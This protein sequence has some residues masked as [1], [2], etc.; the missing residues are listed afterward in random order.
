LLNTFIRLE[1]KSKV[2]KFV[3]IALSCVIWPSTVMGGPCGEFSWDVSP[4]M[5]VPEILRHGQDAIQAGQ[6][7]EA[8]DMFATYL[9]EQEEGKFAE[10]SRWVMAS[11]P[12]PSDVSGREIFQRITR[13]QAMKTSDPDSVYAPWALCATGNIY[14]E[15]GWFSEASGIFEEFLRS[16]PEHPLAGG[17]MV[18][19]GL[20]YMSNRQYLE[21]ALVLRRVVEEPKWSAHRLKGALGLADATAMAKAWKQAYYWYRVVEAERPELIRQSGDSSYQYGLS[22]LV[23]GNPETAI[24]RFLLT[25]NLHPHRESAGMA[26]NQISEQLRKEGHE[27]LALYFADQARQQFPDQ[28]PGRRGQ[29]A[30]TRWVVA[31]VSQDHAK[32]DW[33]KVYHRFDDLE[34]YL[35]LSW[36]YV[37]ETTG[38]LTHAPESD[39]ADESLLWMGQAYQALGEFAEAVNT[40]TRLVIVASSDTRRQE[41]KYRLARL[42]QD[43]IRSFYE[44]KAW[45]PLLKFHADHQDAFQLVPLERERLLMVAQAYQEVN[46]PAEAWHWYDQLLQEYPNSPLREN[47]RLQQVVVAQEQGIGSL[48]RDAGTSYLQEFPKGQGRG[49]VETA[50]GMEAFTDKRYAEAIRDFSAALQHVEGEVGQRYVLRNRARAYR[51]LGQMESVVQDMRQVVSLEPAQVSDVL[52][53]ADDMFDQGDYV[54][55]QHLYDQTLAFDAPP[56]LLTWAKYRL[57]ASLERMG[58]FSEAATLL[59]ELRALQTRSPELEHTIRSA[60]TAVLDEMSSKET[61]PTR[62]PD[63]PIQS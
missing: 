8:R 26:L 28:E 4:D 23:V 18:E 63:A 27:Y 3:W 19:A 11:L 58:K 45:V 51:A 25:V 9:K 54:E 29:A 1:H 57:A 16:Y 41:G 33:A 32:E 62:I 10:G 34:L 7:L 30:L 15:A 14:W 2:R 39:V 21:A 36:D 60:A 56:A 37:L 50:L 20:G 6:L 42:L 53:L 38:A 46:L 12:D 5:V 55:A 52:R 40:F 13:L 35:S 22:E 49:Q 31:F 24:S 47:I 59:A 43:Q 44:G 17:V 61:P 48:V